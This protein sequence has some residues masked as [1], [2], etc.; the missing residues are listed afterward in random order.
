ML[1]IILQGIIQG[2]TEFLPVSSSGHLLFFQSLTRFKGPYLLVDVVLHAGTLCVILAYYFNDLKNI[3]FKFL[4]NPFNLNIKEVKL[5]WLILLANIPTGISGLIIKKYFSSI[6]NTSSLLFFTWGLMGIL[7]IVSDKVKSS[8][9]DI[10]SLTPFYALMIGLAQGIAI[11]PGI[12]R[13]GI[14]I[15]TGLVLSLKREEA[16]RFSFLISIPALLG[17]IMMEALDSEMISFSFTTL[18]F[19]F[20]FS[21]IFGLLGI[22]TLLKL[23]Q[24]AKFFYFGIYLLVLVVILGFI[25]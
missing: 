20:I 19:G 17:S 10:F 21:F 18:G 11:L 6:F 22:I 2:L 12:S 23:L 5:A 25:K 7:L 1:N 4:P 3:L 14:T 24:K 15:I 9:K 16:A 13:S 8:K